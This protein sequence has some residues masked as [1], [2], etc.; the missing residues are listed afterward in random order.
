MA[1]SYQRRD[2]LARQQ[3]FDS[4]YDKRRTLEF[5]NAPRSSFLRVIGERA[6]GQRHQH[7]EDARLYYQAFKGGP[8]NDYRAYVNAE[9]EMV[10]RRGRGA[11]AKWLVEK[12][13]YVESYEA[14]LELYPNGKR[15]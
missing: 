1:Y 15:E 6:G 9:G 10:T 11:R 12:A 14:W 4:Y 2:E 7:Y 13:Q 3:G 5:A 8:A